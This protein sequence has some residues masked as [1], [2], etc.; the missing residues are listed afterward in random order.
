MRRERFTA[1]QERL[2][3][4]CLGDEFGRTVLRG[5]EHQAAY[6]LQQRK[7]VTTY[8]DDSSNTLCELVSTEAEERVRGALGVDQET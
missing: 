6:A 7:L 1:T 8:T 5:G 3:R 2:L 4:A